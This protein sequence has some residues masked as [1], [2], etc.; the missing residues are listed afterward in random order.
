MRHIEDEVKRTTRWN[1]QACD[2]GPRDVF[3]LKR[4]LLS[5]WPRVEELQADECWIHVDLELIIVE[6]R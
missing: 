6:G 3:L 5:L 2:L 1:G 4:M